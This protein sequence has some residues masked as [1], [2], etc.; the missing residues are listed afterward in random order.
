M[1]DEE[2]TASVTGELALDPKVDT[3]GIAVSTNHGTATLRGTVGSFRAKREARRAAK[4]VDGVQAV[5][6]QLQ[7]RL[8]VGQGRADADLRGEILREM[9]LN[10]MIPATIEVVVVDAYVTL[11]G[12]AAWDYQPG[13]AETVAGNVDGV[14]GIDNFVELTTPELHAGAVQKSIEA[15][16]ERDTKVDADGLTVIT[17]DNTVELEGRVRS[18][19]EHDAALAAA[20]A[21]PGVLS[22]EDR[23]TVSN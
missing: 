10:S 22:V 23:L 6:N 1:S 9:A 5:D 7:V 11:Q 19:S 18:W 14:V 12:T 13:Q 4:R 8:L 16:F 17:H 3:A 21:I 15:A 2:L 20:W